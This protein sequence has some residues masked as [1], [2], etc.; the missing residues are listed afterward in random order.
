[1]I[2]LKILGS[3][4]II[5][6]GYMFGKH[7]RD[8]MKNRVDFYTYLVKALYFIDNKIAIENMYLDEVM[9]QVITDIYSDTEICEPFSQFNIKLKDG[10]QSIETTWK[11][12]CDELFAS[13][14]YIKQDERDDIYQIGVALGLSDRQR[15]SDSLK[16]ICEKLANREKTILEKTKKDSALAMKIS[17]VFAVMLVVLII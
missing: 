3:I 6:S 1:M 4:L 12:S 17:L 15:Q 7:I 2:I 11:E 16:L 9:K 14:D 5:L 10:E 13:C 8:D